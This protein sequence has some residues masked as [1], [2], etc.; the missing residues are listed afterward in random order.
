EITG[1][2][3]IYTRRIPRPRELRAR[4][5]VENQWDLLAPLGIAPP[6][7]V[8]DPLEMPIDAAAAA[9]VDERLAAAGVTRQ[10]AVIVIH[11]SAGNPSRRWPAAHFI[12]LIVALAHE[13]E[14][15]RIVVTAGP[16]ERDAASRVIAD[17]RTRLG[18]ARADQVVTCGEFSLTELRALVER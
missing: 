9:A 13:D 4:H 14:R 1:R 3:W 8:A 10:D 12:E 15:R 7:R 11:V 5:S 18:P 2:S 6:D 17:S 16:S